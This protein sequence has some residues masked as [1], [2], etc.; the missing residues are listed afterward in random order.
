LQVDI[1]VH[2]KLGFVGAET[3]LAASLSTEPP[4]DWWSQTF[5]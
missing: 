4:L 3:R 5:Q 1:Y 2:K